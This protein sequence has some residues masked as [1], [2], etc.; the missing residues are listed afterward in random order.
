[1]ETTGHS[2][3]P[4]P[5]ERRPVIDGAVARIQELDLANHLRE[6]RHAAEQQVFAINAK[7]AAVGDAHE[8]A[9]GSSQ[10]FDRVL[11]RVYV[12]PHEARARFEGAMGN[13][14]DAAARATVR[15]AM[16]ED[17]GTFGSLRTE[18]RP[19]A[20]G[21]LHVDVDATARAYAPQAARLGVR[22]TV[23]EEQ[24]R[25]ALGPEGMTLV[26][27]HADGYARV[28][29]GLDVALDAAKHRV[30]QIDVK[31]AGLP[32]DAALRRT[33][34]QALGAVLPS[35][36][37]SVANALSSRQVALA[38]SLRFT[39]KLAIGRERDVG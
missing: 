12:N 2:N 11:A 4:L 6:Q 8:R 34:A 22:A 14:P 30:A 9:V 33:A 27:N 37:A 38:V 21:L 24:L 36:L 7:R 29:A 5:P 15:R 19:L 16:A 31:R 25:H 32:D 20:R 13:D 39:S 1:M 10:A 26:R 18:S 28:V 17:P 3:T 23:L 35:E